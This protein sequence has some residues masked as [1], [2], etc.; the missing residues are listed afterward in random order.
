M[1]L[2]VVYITSRPEPCFEWFLHSLG[3]QLDALGES[4]NLILVNSRLSDYPTDVRADSWGRSKCTQVPPK[5]TVW[6]GAHRLTKADWWAA[7][8]AR[9]TGIC[10]CQTEWIAFVDDRC[11]LA[12]TW[13]QAVRDAMAGNYAVFGSYEKR[14]GM[15]VE[16]GIIKHGG[17]VQATD[18]RHDYAAKFW[19]NETPHD[20]PGEWSYGCTLALP[21]EWALQVNGLD[22]NCDGLSFEDVI[23]GLMLQNNGYPMKFDYRMKI[24]EDRTPEHLGPAMIRKD[25][26]VSPND[27][28]HALLRA[29]EVRKTAS[30]PINLR[31]IRAD[32]LAGKPFPPPWGPSKDWWDQQPVSEM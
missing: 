4:V 11:V 19:N 21:L 23:F 16:N 3:A 7:S 20:C 6:Q 31:Q 13:L 30:H 27:K 9:N 22:E 14:H 18:S 12:P 5:P 15:T 25:K 8:N 28:S 26:G 2:T 17:I 29:L 10:L 1:Q 24:I 32:A